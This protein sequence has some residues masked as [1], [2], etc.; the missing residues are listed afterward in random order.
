MQDVSNISVSFM[1]SSS[2]EVLYLR[3]ISSKT[4]TQVK[5]PWF[6]RTSQSY[7]PSKISQTINV[8]SVSTFFYETCNTL[9]K[10]P[11]WKIWSFD[12]E[13]GILIEN[14]DILAE[15]DIFQSFN[16]FHLTNVP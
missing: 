7:S 13:A 1:L 12:K 9:G 14:K 3:Y 2:N 16:G 15:R 4:P 8:Q 10:K 5:H 6:K 11:F